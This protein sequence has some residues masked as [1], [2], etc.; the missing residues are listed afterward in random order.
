METMKRARDLL[1]LLAIGL[2]LLGCAADGDS[3]ATDADISPEPG[4]SEILR[5]YVY[6][7]D[8]AYTWTL[9]NSEASDGYTLHTIE[10]TSQTWLTEAEVDRPPWTHWLMVVEPDEVS[11]DHAFLYISGGRNGGDPPEQANPLTLQPAL[12][13][14]SFTAELRMVPNQ[15]LNFVGD[16]YG[17]RVEDELIAYGW[18][19]FL[20][21]ED[22]IWLAR[23]PMTKAAVRAMDTMTAFAASDDGG[24]KDVNRFVV[25]GGSKR[26]WTTW[27]TAMVD[28]RVVAIAP[29]VIDLLNLEPSFEHHWKAYGFWAPAIGDYVHE[30]ITDWFGTPEYME[31]QM[32]VEPYNHL[33]KLTMPKYLIN[34][35]GDQFF[36]PDSAQFYFDD[37]LGEK[38]LRYV[39]NTEHSLGG[40]DAAVGF[41][42][43][44]Q[45]I[46]DGV[47]RPD[48][49]WSIE[50]D[51][52]G[53]AAITAWV[54]NDKQPSQ[55]LLWQASNPETRDLRVD[56]IGRSWTSTP[57]EANE[58]GRWIGAVPAP[59]RG[60]TGFYLEFE[61]PGPGEAPF[62][63]STEIKVVPEDL[64][65]GWPPEVEDG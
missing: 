47:E 16:D 18:D 59:E 54:A 42:A 36:L 51:D 40:S 20:R 49:D 44:Y 21:G 29:I 50:T 58:D 56:T 60:W 27:T 22:A 2:L 7:P 39:P 1:T 3:G 43:F 46:L 30:G 28:D 25:A 14:G 31:L 23:L 45:A 63:F 24:G 38:H 8:P 53:G 35:T 62:Q 32:I 19:K 55:V 37:L 17:E 65:F 4:S 10:M 61:F 12:A 9:V 26:G 6:T 48:V 64:P 15:P 52:A 11:S 5:D 33:D 41:L 34:A 13:T 57:V